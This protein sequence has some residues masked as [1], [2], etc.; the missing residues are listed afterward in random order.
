MNLLTYKTKYIETELLNLLIPQ[1][2][3]M[4][5]DGIKATRDARK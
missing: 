3:E 1:D 4:D 2:S 5:S